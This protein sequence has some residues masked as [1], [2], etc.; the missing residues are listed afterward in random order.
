MPCEEGMRTF[1]VAW[2]LVAAASVLAATPVAA[3]TDVPITGRAVA[4]VARGAARHMLTFRSGVDAGIAAPFPDPTAGASLLVHVSNASGQCRAEVALPAVFWSPIGDDGPQKGWRYR[5]AGGSALGVVAVTIAPR[6]SG[7]GRITLKAKGP[8]FPCTLEVAQ[9]PPVTV[10]L[11]MGSTR[12]CAAFDTATVRTNKVGR[13]RAANAPAPP[14][15]PDGDLTVANLNVLHGLFCPPATVGCRLAERVALLREWLVARGCPDVVTLQEIADTSP[16]LSILPLIE[17]ELLDACPTPYTRVYQRTL[18]LDDEMIL[19]RWPILSSALIDLYGPLRHLLHARLDHPIGPVDVYSTH[20]A[21]GSDFATNPCGI[22]GPCPAE[23]TGAGAATVRDCQAVQTA[24]AV[25]ATH[26]VLAPALLTGDFNESPGS[27]VYDQFA[28]RGWADSYLAVGNPEC[29]PATGVGCTSGR[30]DED[31]SHLED[32][33][34]NQGERIDF[35]WVIPPGP[36]SVCSAMLDGPA[37]TDGDGVATRLFAEL[38]NPFAPSCGP[39]PAAICWVSDHS[40]TQADL[41]C[42]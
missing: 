31:L 15:C 7:G 22:F 26:D 38:P 19:S 34:L 18:G 6:R 9:T 39:A 14:A 35:V 41:N 37:D 3:A 17:S 23:C 29:V 42:N 5:D 21:S 10:T 13:F 32:P 25:E 27:Y 12:Y 11:G 8:S 4:I 40:G 2:N 16:T 24:L 30:N 33:A 1:R 36:G 28:N 20:L